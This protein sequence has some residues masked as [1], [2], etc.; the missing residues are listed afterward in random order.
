MKIVS[1]I[2]TWGGQDMKF[3]KRSAAVA[4]LTFAA[5]AAAHAEINVGI[6]LA[7]TG[8]A[9]SAGLPSRPPNFSGVMSV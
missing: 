3:F 2:K 9:A 7:L 1:L 8:P 4:A 6:T 5:V